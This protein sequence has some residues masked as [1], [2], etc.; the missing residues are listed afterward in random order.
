MWPQ[1]TTLPCALLLLVATTFAARAQDFITASTDLV[2]NYLPTAQ[3]SGQIV[4]GIAVAGAASTDKPRLLSLI[5]ASWAGSEVCFSLVSDDGRYKAEQQFHVK[6]SWTGGHVDVPF[7]SGYEALLSGTTRDSLGVLL[8]RGKCGSNDGEPYAMVGWNIDRPTLPGDATLL[9]NTFRADEAYLIDDKG[10]EV[11]CTPRPS[12]S[13]TAFDFS[14]TLPNDVAY[15]DG[16]LTFE[17]NRIRRGTFD[18]GVE[19]EI[20]RIRADK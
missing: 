18:P 15:G 4:A 2:E 9:V 3:I 20:A 13:R 10:N 17:I 1:K 6:E 19:I 8:R 7:K 12:E 16:T 11:A 5:P 14:C